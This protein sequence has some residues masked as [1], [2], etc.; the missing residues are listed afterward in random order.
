MMPEN[1]NAAENALSVNITRAIN[2][3]WDD[4]QMVE[5]LSWIGSGGLSGARPEFLR[6]ALRVMDGYPDS[7]QMRRIA[8][9]TRAAVACILEGQDDAAA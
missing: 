5:I 7:Q 4:G 1:G 6:D 9:A 2:D 3:E 8:D